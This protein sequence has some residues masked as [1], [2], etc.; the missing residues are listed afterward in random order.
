MAFTVYEFANLPNAL[1]AEVWPSTGANVVTTVA[2]SA[3][4]VTAPGTKHI[5]ITADADG[6][7]TIGSANT[8]AATSIPILSAIPNAFTFEGGSTTLK[9]L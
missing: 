9:F 8:A 4:H 7:M 5:L 1:D 2:A 6:R 3:T